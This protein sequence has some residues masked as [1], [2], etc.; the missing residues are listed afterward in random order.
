MLE[1]PAYL[2][3]DFEF[4]LQKLLK[5]ESA[6]RELRVRETSYAAM[7]HVL[8]EHR[9]DILLDETQCES[10][11]SGLIRQMS[12]T[13][14]PP[15]SLSAHSR[16]PHH[17]RGDAYLWESERVTLAHLFV[18][19]FSVIACGRARA[20]LTWVHVSWRRCC[21]TVLPALQRIAGV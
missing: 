3:A 11:V 20:R 5:P 21:S 1:R 7:L 16:T 8:K 6:L 4:N 12:I 17:A 2:P 18:F 10:F 14:G 13:Q 19:S 15:V 9:A